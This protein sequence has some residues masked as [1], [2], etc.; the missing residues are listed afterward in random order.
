MM[1]HPYP[2]GRQAYE[3][4]CFEL[5][6]G[7]SA[8]N[9]YRQAHFQTQFGGKIERIDLNKDAISKLEENLSGFADKV[10]DFESSYK[11][12]EILGPA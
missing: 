7:K 2:Y 10:K 12:R 8:Y 3:S 4:P 6:H 9:F 1:T 11:L 5:E